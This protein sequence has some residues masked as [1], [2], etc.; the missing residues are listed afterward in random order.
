MDKQIEYGIKCQKENEKQIVK[1][2]NNFLQKEYEY[3]KMYKRN[4]ESI[5]KF[6]YEYYYCQFI[7]EKPLWY[8]DLYP[9]EDLD[10]KCKFENKETQWILFINKIDI[11]ENTSK[12]NEALEL[13]FQKL[14]NGIGFET[15]LL[16]EY[17]ENEERI[18]NYTDEELDEM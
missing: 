3:R 6:N 7:K 2:I 11:K 12:Q 17:K 4:D 8:F 14:L 13:F 10:G 16:Y 5:S 15:I 18:G 9:N 1:N